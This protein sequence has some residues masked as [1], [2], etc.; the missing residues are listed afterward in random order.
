MNRATLSCDIISSTQ[1]TSS[2]KREWD[3]KIREL[4]RELT[5]T[6]ASESFF[7]RLIK[8]DYIECAMNNPGIS[9]RI[10]LII[11]TFIK[12][13][14]TEPK[15]KDRKTR[16]F[17]EHGI[18][19]AIA[20]APLET[21]EPEKNIIDGKAIHLSGRALQHQETSGKKKIIIKNTLFFVS[22]N[23]DDPEKYEN[24][25]NLIDVLI[26]KCSSRQCEILYHKLLG[27]SEKE[28]AL[29]LGKSQSA[30]NQH[31]TTAGWNAMEKTVKYIEK[32]L[33]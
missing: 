26:S 2:E 27:K 7:G 31:S 15:G 19:I 24:M 33:V 10:A 16:Y 21:F 12:S 22:E 1:I 30:I 25:I 6:Y 8:G 20:V 32:S 29:I 11:K 18:R 3:E 4:L 17:R 28:L 23:V 13:L 14:S 5:V 9:L